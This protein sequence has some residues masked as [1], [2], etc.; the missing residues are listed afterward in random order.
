MKHILSLVAL[1]VLIVGS[2]GYARADSLTDF[3][4]GAQCGATYEAS[5]TALHDAIV[6]DVQRDDFP[7]LDADQQAMDSLNVD[8]WSA[9]RRCEGDTCK[10]TPGYRIR[11]RYLDKHMYA[12]QMTQF[13][14]NERAVIDR[15]VAEA[16]YIC[17]EYV[18]TDDI[19]DHTERDTEGDARVLKALDVIATQQWAPTAV[20]ADDAQLF[21]SCASEIAASNVMH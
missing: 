19:L 16:H 14:G 21:N 3:A 2:A 6:A 17:A 7:K 13:R 11:S 15:L 10:S 18:T 5:Y 20:D 8:C 1:V 12:L 4:V 9:L